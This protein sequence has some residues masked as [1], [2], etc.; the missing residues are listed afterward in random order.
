MGKGDKDKDSEESAQLVGSTNDGESSADKKPIGAPYKCKEKHCG[1]YCV[2]CC[3]CFFGLI[4]FPFMLLLTLLAVFVWVILLPV[5]C[6]SPCCAPL[7]DLVVQ[8]LM[9]P[10][11]LYKWILGKDEEEI[12]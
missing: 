5:K 1:T 3:R 9:L 12:A 6:C 2:A 7:F 4:L 10:V 8:V 11:R